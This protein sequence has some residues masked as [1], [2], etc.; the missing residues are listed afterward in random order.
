MHKVFG[1]KESAEYLD[2]E[3]AYL[4]PLCNN[5]ICV[6][7][8]DKGYFLGQYADNLPNGVGVKIYPNGDFLYGKF[9][10]GKL[11][12][13]AVYYH[14][15]TQTFEFNLYENGQEKQENII[16]DKFVVKGSWDNS[17][18]SLPQLNN[19]KYLFY[20]RN[21]TALYDYLY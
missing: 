1:K 15:N 7:Q 9:E 2:R 3:G 6:I 12:N 11:Q 18:I 14:A 16:N 10:K 21:R 19:N 20:K 4:I 13:K 5:Q 8:T 17:L